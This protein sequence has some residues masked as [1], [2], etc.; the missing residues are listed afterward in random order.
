MKQPTTVLALIGLIFAAVAMFLQ[1]PIT[2]AEAR[3]AVA[4]APIHDEI[5]SNEFAT[6]PAVATESSMVLAR[7]KAIAAD[8]EKQLD[9]EKDPMADLCHSFSKLSIKDED[10][11]FRLLK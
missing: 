11:G 2:R 10:D 8:E 1:Q 9:E 4:P 6:R 7:T 3:V 5:K